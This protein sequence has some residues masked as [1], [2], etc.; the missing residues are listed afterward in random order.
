MEILY[1][2]LDYFELVLFL[3]LLSIGFFV[4]RILEQKHFNSIRQRERESKNIL[5]FAARFPPNLAQPQDCT[6]VC[7]QVVISSDYFK[8]FVA[9]LR[10]LVGGRFRGY[11]SLFDRARREAVLRMKDEARNKGYKMIVNVRFETTSLTGGRQGA[12]PSFEVVA[13][14]TAVR[15]R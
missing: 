12:L 6:L 8:Q 9:G 5:V 3:V 15:P 4:G 14:G 13:Y 1:F 11:E 7:G 2:V 10:S